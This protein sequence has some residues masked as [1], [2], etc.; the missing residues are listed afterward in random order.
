MRA[1][2]TASAVQVREPAHI[3]SVGRWRRYAARLQP[4]IDV[5]NG[6]GLVAVTRA[7][8]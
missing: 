3:R 5:L 4:M 6:A 7:S 8:R 1:V 2:A